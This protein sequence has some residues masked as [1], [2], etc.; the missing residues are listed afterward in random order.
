MGKYINN[1]K[2]RGL[3]D[4]DM[5]KY[6]GKNEVLSE[7]EADR[8]WDILAQGGEGA[9]GAREKLIESN[10]RLVVSIAKQYKRGSDCGELVELTMMGMP[11]LIN[12]VDHFDRTMN[13][14]FS[15]F[16]TTAI[17]N[18][19]LKNLYAINSNI[20]TTGDARKKWTQINTYIEEAG[21]M[22]SIDAI[23]KKTGIDYGTVYGIVNMHYSSYVSMEKEMNED[24]EDVFGDFVKDPNAI[25]CEKN[26]M[27]SDCREIVA[28]ILDSLPKREGDVLRYRYGF[29]DG[30]EWTLNEIAMLP[31]F[32]CSSSRIKKI[33]V[34]A[35]RRIRR[36]S[37]FKNNLYD[38]A[39]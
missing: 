22:P 10:Y 29:V 27:D 5:M 11:G 34:D 8:L 9:I 16:A 4:I 24:N 31:E 1:D 23:A 32:S 33:Q 30:R 36:N 2:I 14:K 13:F 18:E 6:F 28:N 26:A 21:C 3:S 7:E 25:N 12:A 37:R 15:T 38:Y 39:M 20:H 19:I 17:K 35:L